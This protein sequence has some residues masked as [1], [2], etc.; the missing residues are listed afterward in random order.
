MDNEENRFLLAALPALLSP[1]PDI[2]EFLQNL[3][4]INFVISKPPPDCDPLHCNDYRIVVTGCMKMRYIY[5][6]EETFL[7]YL[8]TIPMDFFKLLVRL[9]KPCFLCLM[10][11][12]CFFTVTRGRN[13]NFHIV[14]VCCC[15]SC[16]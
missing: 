16:G 13:T 1:P 6:R 8:V 12:P 3:M 14:I 5:G 4:G 9:Q 15:I 10:T 7:V 11:C 2:T